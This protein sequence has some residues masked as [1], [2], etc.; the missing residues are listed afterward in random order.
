[1]TQRILPGKQVYNMLVGLVGSLMIH[2]EV[3][4]KSEQ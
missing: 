1:M 4:V 2:V 3:D